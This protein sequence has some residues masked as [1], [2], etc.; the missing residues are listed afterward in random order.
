MPFSIID[1]F[2]WSSFRGLIEL[3][4]RVHRDNG[5]KCDG[6]TPPAAPEASL[7]H[8]A[9]DRSGGRREN[10]GGWS[11]WSLG[12]LWSWLGSGRQ[13]LFGDIFPYPRTRRRR[14]LFG[15][16]FP[17]PCPRRRP[18]TAPLCCPS[19]A[20]LIRLDSLFLFF[21]PACLSCRIGTRYLNQAPGN[22]SQ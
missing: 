7:V 19:S 8:S 4:L 2:F 18:F 5:E 1:P 16:I 14:S 11:W 3:C 13:S 20:Y 9:P 17:Y 21:F 10:S 15:D 12:P 22:P 6:V